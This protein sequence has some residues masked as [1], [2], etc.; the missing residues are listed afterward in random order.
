MPTE[1]TRVSGRRR[2]WT[3]ADTLSGLGVALAALAL[4]KVAGGALVAD[5]QR[6]PP[7][8][9]F[10]AHEERLQGPEDEDRLVKGITLYRDAANAMLGPVEQRQLGLLLL[11]EG[12]RTARN[13]TPTDRQ[14]AAD[15]AI[16]ALAASLHR[17]PVQPLTWTYLTDVALTLENRP[18]K[19]LRTLKE[20]YRVAPIDPNLVLYRFEL[21]IRLRRHWDAEFLRLIRPDL[22][23]LFEQGGHPKRGEFIQLIRA[24]PKL[25]PIATIILKRTPDAL[26]RYQRAITPPQRPKKAS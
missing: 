26:D 15:T 22:I 18:R 17:A 1:P 10:E 8:R 4:L 23:A 5:L 21:A 19:A 7:N 12:K 20:S 6:I 2:P 14:S 11:L 13:M 3:R 25:H 24:N 16:S 9:F